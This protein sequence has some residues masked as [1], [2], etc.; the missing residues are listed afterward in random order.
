MIGSI[1]LAIC[2]ICP[3][4]DLFDQWD[5]TLQTGHDSEY[6]MVIV[7]LCVGAAFELGHLIARL[8]PDLSR[9]RV[10]S[11]VPSGLRSLGFAVFPITSASALAWASP[12]FSLRI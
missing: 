5:H 3:L 12:P 9:S 4:T 10:S 2:L 1:A 6:P 8:S 11:D 7:A